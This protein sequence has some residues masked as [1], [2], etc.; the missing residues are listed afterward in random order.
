M[1]K[2]I[3]L[4]FFRIRTKLKE[5]QEARR[6]PWS[7]SS[8]PAKRRSTGSSSV[9]ESIF[10]AG[11]GTALLLAGTAQGRCSRETR[12]GLRKTNGFTGE[13]GKAFLFLLFFVLCPVTLETW[14][15]SKW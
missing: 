13:C 6:V 11:R 9:Y 12:L 8:L 15:P 5:K 7:F 14:Y 4:V 3:L 2:W 10:G 1:R